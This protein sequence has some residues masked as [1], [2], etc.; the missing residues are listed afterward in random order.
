MCVLVSVVVCGERADNCLAVGTSEL[1][2]DL[3]PKHVQANF[4]SF[5]GCLHCLTGK[6][7]V[8]GVGTAD[9][10]TPQ[11]LGM[12]VHPTTGLFRKIKVAVES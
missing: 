5:I 12:V 10:G 8:V 4:P 2:R 6:R 3:G 1:A 11:P 7:S 9:P